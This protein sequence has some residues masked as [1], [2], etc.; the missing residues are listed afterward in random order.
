MVE[1]D[2]AVLEE[3]RD[4]GEAGRGVVDGVLALIVAQRRARHNQVRVR[5]NFERVRPG[6]YAG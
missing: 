2:P 5:D 3:R 4:L 1:V 6:L